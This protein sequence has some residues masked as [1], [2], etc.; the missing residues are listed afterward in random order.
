[1]L[2]GHVLHGRSHVLGASQQALHLMQIGDCPRS[3]LGSH[4]A[5]CEGHPQTGVGPGL[6]DLFVDEPQVLCADGHVPLPHELPESRQYLA[7]SAPWIAEPL[8]R[9]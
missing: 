5:H 4:R 9:G 7:R 6:G 2:E 3:G 1:M 8:L